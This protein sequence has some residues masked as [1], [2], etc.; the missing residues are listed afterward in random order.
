MKNEDARRAATLADVAERAGVSA[1]TV[2]R[3]VNEHPSVRDTTRERVKA[4]IAETGFQLNLAARSLAASQSYLIGTFVADTASLYYSELARGAARACRALGYHLVTEEFDQRNPVAADHYERTLRQTRCD[5]MIL[6]PPLCDDLALLDALER[7]GVRYVRISPMLDPDRSVAVFAHDADGVSQL[8][9]HL[10]EKGHRRFGVING[11]SNFASSATRR[12]A[13]IAAVCALGG[14]AS[15]VTASKMLWD[16]TFPATGYR[17]TGQLLKDA[18]DISA[19]FTFNDELA[20]G[21]LGYAHENGL[22]VPKDLAVAG[23]DDS[24]ASSFAWPSLTTVSQPVV[25][26]AVRA[27]QAL[28]RDSPHARRRIECPVRLV[29]RASTGGE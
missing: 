16:G 3:V 29:I 1:K 7:D 5:G 9:R 22:R 20:L 23:F 14:S 4:V 26:M 15:D 21:V 18:P 19:I 25:D 8:A 2:S 13:L 27:V 12:D 10:W 28:V 11:P 17:T 24:D 6:P